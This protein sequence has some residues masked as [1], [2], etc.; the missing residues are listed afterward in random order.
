MTGNE[1]GQL[2]IQVGTEHDEFVLANRKY[3]ASQDAFLLASETRRAQRA[4]RNE[5]IEQAMKALNAIRRE[6]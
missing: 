3:Q 2:L 1:L 6:K 4:K 5:V